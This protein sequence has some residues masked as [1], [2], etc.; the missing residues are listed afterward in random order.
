MRFRQNM[1]IQPVA[2]D[3]LSVMPG[4][5]FWLRSTTVMLSRP[6]K[7]PSKTLWPSASTRLTHQAKLMSS[8]WKHFSRNFRSPRPVRRRSVS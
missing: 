2:S 3:C 7:P 4:G 5:N 1:P 6:R 8:L